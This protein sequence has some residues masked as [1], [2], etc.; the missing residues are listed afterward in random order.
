MPGSGP[1]DGPSDGPRLLRAEITRSFAGG[2]TTVDGSA[3]SRLP[4][5][6]AEPPDRGAYRVPPRSVA[7]LAALGEA[8]KSTAVLLMCQSDD[9]N[10]GSVASD[11]LTGTLDGRTGG[12]AVH[13]A[14]VV[15]DGVPRITL[16][17]IVPGSGSGEPAGTRG[18]FVLTREESGQHVFSVAYTLPESAGSA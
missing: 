13:R 12:F 9:E 7:L 2:F 15:D 17:A 8:G 18:A 3:A 11:H 16:G 14:G 1:S 6:P 4:S 10:A 5:V